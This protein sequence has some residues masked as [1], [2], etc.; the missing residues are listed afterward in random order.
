MNAMIV[1]K[2]LI[3]NGERTELFSVVT[4]ERVPQ[5]VCTS[6]LYEGHRT[7]WTPS[8]AEVEATQK[9]IEATA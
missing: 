6:L 2:V 9:E 3:E 8:R 4:S 5:S 7:A 1:E